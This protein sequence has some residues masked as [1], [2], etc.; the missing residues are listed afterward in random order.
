MPTKSALA[1]VFSVFLFAGVML[2]QPAQQTTKTNHEALSSVDRS[3]INSAQEGNLAEIEIAKIVEQKAT[4][5]AVKDFANRF[6]RALAE[7]EPD[8]FVATMAKAKRKG[9]IF[10]DYLRNERGSTAVLPYV[11]RARSGA[12]VAVPVTWTELRDLDSAHHW[13][14]RDGAALVERANSRAL[15]GWGFADQVLPDL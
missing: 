5:P 2:A 11:A 15:A 14:V 6:A 13:G 1:V 3:F 7:A 12:P 9:R 4:D 8:R 10:I